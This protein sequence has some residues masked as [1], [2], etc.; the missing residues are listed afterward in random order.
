MAMTFKHSNGFSRCA[1]AA[2]G[3]HAHLHV[4]LDTARILAV[5]ICVLPPVLA[6]LGMA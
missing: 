4:N 6:E 1:S 3:T 5:S 2:A